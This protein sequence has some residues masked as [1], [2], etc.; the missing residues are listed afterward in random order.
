MFPRVG[1]VCCVGVIQEDE[2]LVFWPDAC[3]QRSA[4]RC[5]HGS[6]AEVKTH[7]LK[8]LCTGFGVNSHFFSYKVN[9]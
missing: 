2:F 8:W 7:V 4:A 9:R 5:I 1:G 6:R 3:A